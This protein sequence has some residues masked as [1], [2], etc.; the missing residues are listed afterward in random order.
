MPNSYSAAS[1]VEASGFV[2]IPEDIL[3][4]HT[5]D[6]LFEAMPIMRY[7]QFAVVKTDLNTIKGGTLIFSKYAN[8]TVGGALKEEDDIVLKS[9]SKT[10]VSIAV[11]EYGNGV[12]ITGKFMTLAFLDEIQVN[13]VLLGKD[14]ARVTDNMLRDSL[15]SGTQVHYCG[16]NANR[17]AI[18]DTDLVTLED[19]DSVVEQLAT[20]NVQKFVDANGEFYVGIFHPHQIRNIKK[21][22]R[23]IQQYAYG[24]MIFKGEVGEYNGVRFVET[25]NTPNGAAVSTDLA[26]SAALDKTATPAL[27]VTDGIYRGVIF[28]QRAYGW[29]IALPV[30]L[31]EDPGY[32]NF[33][34][35]RG[36]AWYAIQG[37]GKIAN[38][39]ICILE[40][41]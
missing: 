35:K 38:E 23:S 14:Y 20:A 27:G 34:R 10:T 11:T 36:L 32:S 6:L 21:E 15:F 24:E 22:L 3:A 18:Q 33:G 40:S 19:I 41:A 17:N 1:T 2:G 29:A 7:D 13:A 30:E 12:G 31:R 28:G 39:S 9:L 4:V 8:L 16:G 37:S 5:N 26:Y 25:A